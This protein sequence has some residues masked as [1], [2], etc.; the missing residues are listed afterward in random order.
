MNLDPSCKTSF[1]GGLLRLAV[2]P[3]HLEHLKLLW[4]LGMAMIGAYGGFRV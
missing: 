4:F 2:L 1:K 3:D